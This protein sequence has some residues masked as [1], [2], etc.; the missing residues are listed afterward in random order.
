[1]IVDNT[2]NKILV[3][4]SGSGFMADALVNNLKEAGFVTEFADPVVSDI[5]NGRDLDA[6]RAAF[7]AVAAIGA[8]DHALGCQQVPGLEQRLTFEIARAK[9]LYPNVVFPDDVAEFSSGLCSEVSVDGYRA[10][11]AMMRTARTS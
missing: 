4:S 7:H 11:I 5:E 1:M 9:E 8:G 3:V 10:D 2:A 6:L